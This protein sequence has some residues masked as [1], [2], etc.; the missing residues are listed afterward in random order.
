MEACCCARGARG[1]DELKAMEGTDVQVY[2]V[3]AQHAMACTRARPGQ[4]AV[5]LRRSDIIYAW[6]TTGA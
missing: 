4:L 2:T 3:T 5:A 6:H 1:C